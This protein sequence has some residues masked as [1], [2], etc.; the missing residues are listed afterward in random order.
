MLLRALAH[1]DVADGRRYQDALVA[2]QRAEHDL[3][4]KPGPVLA[5]PVE[6]NPG[7]DLLRQ[8]LG[9][10]AGSVGD[11]PLRKALRND[12][13]HL[14]AQE[15]IAAVSKLALHP[16]VQQNNLAA[17]VHHHDSIRSRLKKA[18]IS[19]FHLRQMLHRIVDRSRIAELANNQRSAGQLQLLRRPDRDGRQTSIFALDV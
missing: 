16:G 11:Q 10:G 18:T 19:G 13:C 14:P 5:P 1:S 9:R 3:D 15:L 6:F 12:G 7:A 8:R 17:L 2:F 4:G